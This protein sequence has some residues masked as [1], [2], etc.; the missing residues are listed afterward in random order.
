MQKLQL[1]DR[2]KQRVYHNPEIGMTVDTSRMN[3]SDNFLAEME[4]RVQQAYGAMDKLEG[5]AIANPDEKRMVGH[6]WLRAP[7]LAPDEALSE[8]IIATQ[9]SIKAFAASAAAAGLAGALDSAARP[10]MTWCSPIKACAL[11][12]NALRL[13]Y[14]RNSAVGAV[15][16]M[17]DP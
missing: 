10:G 16:D 3:F 6:Y 2:Y 7:E 14:G 11:G 13:P 4:P 5:G 1:W 12:D 8:E 17:R 15:L 9:A